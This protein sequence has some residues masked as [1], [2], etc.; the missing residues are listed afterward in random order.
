MLDLLQWVQPPCSS[1]LN[2]SRKVIAM[3]I[4]RHQAESTQ[5]AAEMEMAACQ[6]LGDTGCHVYYAACSLSARVC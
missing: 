5:G 2:V 6:K 4:K 1:S 3:S